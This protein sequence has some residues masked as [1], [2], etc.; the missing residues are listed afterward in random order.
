MR[1][2]KVLF[3]GRLSDVAGRMEMPMPW[4]AEAIKL[5]TLI[6][7]VADGAPHLEQALR[8][9]EIRVCVNLDIL[10]KGQTAFVSPGDEVAF[11]PPMSG[12]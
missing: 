4:F 11:L 3:F 5:D 10:A 12:G 6:E 1:A 7:L 9:P 8:A 2:G